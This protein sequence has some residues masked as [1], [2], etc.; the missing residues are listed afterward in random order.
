MCSLEQFKID[1][2]GLKDEET[3]LTFD[4][5]DCFFDAL[6]DSAV[7]HGALHVSVSIRKITGFFELLFHVEGT[8][9]VTCD[10]CLDDM[11]QPVENEGRLIAKLG[12][13]YSEEDDTITVAEDEGILD[14]AW[15]IYELIALAIPIRHVHAPGKC[16]PAMSKV[17]EELA[18]DR[19]SDA[20]S[21]QPVDPRW[22]KLKDLK[23]NN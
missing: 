23:I 16:N 21:D 13:V 4:V 18:A 20:V 10:L 15:Y 19:S 14:T 9:I 11:V 5:D 8:V 17:L 6:D 3:T 22:S 7:E 2:K 12:T 1:L